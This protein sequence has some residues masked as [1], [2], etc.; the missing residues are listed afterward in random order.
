M[1][2]P[3]APRA[4]LS[5]PRRLAPAVLAAIAAIAAFAGACDDPDQFLPSFQPGGPA[6]ALDGSL[7]YSGPLPCTENGH[8]V[9]AA[10]LL[11][12]D[13]R[14]LPPPE[15]LG[16]TAGSIGVVA[17]DALFAGVRDRLTF[18]GDNSRW[19]PAA[20]APP[21]TVSHAWAIAP[22][23]GATYQ[24][25]G[26]YD[27]DGNFDPGFGISNLPTKGDIGGGAIDNVAE[28]LT[29]AAPR[30]REIA[31]GAD[32]GKGGRTIPPEGSRI[33][34]ISITLGLE[35][36]LDRPVFYPKA[37]ADKSKVG[38]KDPQKVT[39]P[40]D[41]QL[42]NYNTFNPGVTEDSFIRITLA[43]GVD[44]AETDLAAAPPFNLPVKMP[45]PTIFFSRQDTNGDGKID[46]NDHIPETDQVPALLP[47]SIFARIADG[48]TDL[49]N[50]A[51]PVVVMQGLT[52]EKSLLNTAFAPPG[53]AETQ[54]EVIIALR[55]AALCLDPAD[56]TK[57]GTLVIAH[58]YDTF[59]DMKPAGMKKS[60][61]LDAMAEDAVKKQLG[62]QF[63][64]T[65]DL[66]YGCL[67]QGRF[68]MNLIYG[69]GQAWSVPNEAGVCAAS[70][71]ESTDGKTCSRKA[72]DA[73]APH[74]ARL[75]SQDVVITVSPP[76]DTAYCTAHPTPS[77]CLPATP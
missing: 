57:N 27:H 37:V 59:N 2:P 52:L 24:V 38:N 42:A 29:G 61:I 66:V 53:L 44:P 8:V 36:P 67:P 1:N 28:V 56:T 10:V 14:L 3:P 25:R 70:E 35:L 40:A 11:V 63:H 60:P 12:F 47:I 7:T 13:V 54:P 77:Q 6:G 32:D 26:F 74:R 75:A 17:G 18:N 41:F 23:A 65:I 43:A 19:C 5:T 71:P 31:L 9:G 58:Q 46:M 64:R 30:Y 20:D 76:V 55:N 16:T 72:G 15:G 21:I 51:K 73:T 4:T 49:T 22:L 34:G 50:Q 69:T 62:V 39:M 45:A 33:G 48:A 68:A